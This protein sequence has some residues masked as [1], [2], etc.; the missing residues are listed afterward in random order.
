[1]TT[2]IVLGVDLGSDDALDAEG[3]IAR[4]AQRLEAAGASDGLWICTYAVDVPD[5]R[6]AAFAVSIDP[7]VEQS[8]DGGQGARLL[9]T[10]L[11]REAFSADGL[12]FE[13]SDHDHR[14]PRLSAPV[15]AETADEPLA[16]PGSDPAA[17]ARAAIRAHAAKAHGRA[18]VYPG[19]AALTGTVTVAEL[20]DTRIEHVRSLDGRPVAHDDRVHTR[21]FVRPRWVEGHLVLHVQ[22]GPGG[23]LVPFEE[24]NPHR[25]C[26]AH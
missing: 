20:L 6:H 16:P 5:G 13:V 8:D 25:C 7:P 26:A 23:D 19:V 1:M 12:D 18:V 24:P 4:A 2:A 11:V 21:D 10:E 9:L 22:P 17:G 14:A 3:V 15:V